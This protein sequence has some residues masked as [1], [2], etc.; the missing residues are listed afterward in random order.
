MGRLPGRRPDPV[1]AMQQTASSITPTHTRYEFSQGGITLALTFFTPAIMNNID[2]LSRPVTYLTWSAK[3]TDGAPHKVS[4]LL[5][6]DPVISVNER[7][8]QV[9]TFRNHTSRLN[10][11]SAG[12]RDQNILNRSGDNLRIDW[13]YF[14][15]AIPKDEDSATAIAPDV[16]K[17]FAETGKPPVSD[18]MGMPQPASR[19]SPHLAASL[20]FGSVGAQPVTRHL[21]V[22]YTEGYAIQYLERN[23]RPYWQRG[24]MPVEQMLDL[25]EAQYSTLDRRANAF[26]AELTA[27]LSRVGGVQ[28]AAIAILAYRQTLA[29]HKLVADVNGDAMLFAKENFSNGCIATVDV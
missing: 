14:H 6:V 27:D 29:A 15:L 13:G 5:E 3:A 7:G 24:N 20:E 12:S 10:V 23:L 8:Q 28:Y 17:A 26:D 22:S 25:A 2:L 18:S 1:P 9:V 19:T 11:L 4:I 21:L 16:A